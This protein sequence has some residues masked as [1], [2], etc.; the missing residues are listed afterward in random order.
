MFVLECIVF[1][2]IKSVSVT[3]RRM[4]RRHRRTGTVSTGTVSTLKYTGTVSAFKL[5]K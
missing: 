3:G 5:I 1:C 4:T 2:S